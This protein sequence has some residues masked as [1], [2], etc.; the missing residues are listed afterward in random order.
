MASERGR[1]PAGIPYIIG[2]EAAERFSYYGMRSI[3][4]VFMT[5]FLMGAEGE[6][7]VMDEAEARGWYHSF[8]QAVYFLPLLGS[9][10][11]DGFLGKYR[12]ILWLS[13]VYCAG[14]LTLA[15][16][17]TRFG[18]ALG[19]GLIALGSGGI[20]PCVS[21]NVGDQFT[22]DNQHLLPKVFSLFYFSIN[23]G[24]FFATL[25]IPV[26][27]RRFG[28]SVAFGLPGLLMFL[29]TFVF[30]L[31]RDRFVRVPPT[32]MDFVR[33]SFS[34]DGLRA[35]GQLTVLLLFLSPF[36][37]LF[38]QTGSAWVLQAKS[39]DLRML[40]V[41]LLPSQVHA[42]NPILV[43][44]FAPLFAYGVY[45]AFERVFP[46]TPLRK[47]GIGFFL[48][49]ASFLIPAYVEVLIAGG[50]RPSVW[51]QIAAYAV[52]TAAEVLV[53]ITALEFF[54]TQAPRRMKSLI[55]A[56]KMLAISLGN[57][58][59]AIVNFAIRGSDGV[60]RLDGPAYYLF[61]AAVMFA[62]ATLFVAF[63]RVYRPKTFLQ[64]GSSDS[65]THEAGMK[66]RTVSA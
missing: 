49:G 42:V 1:W 40:G 13:L 36:Y 6:L 17:E 50:G 53:S 32:G 20:K 61:F 45:P 4:V 43:M 15:L 55:M 64:D 46:L 58:F 19:L 48:A 3:L 12:T 57:G 31:G 35:L 29:A 33:E 21:A 41:E 14:H 47:M 59:T 9:V 44:V 65:G 30:W 28:P 52:I 62:S 63:A 11:S 37:A 39:M 7:Q 34:V 25:L 56:L 5:E 66:S 8:A 26:L 16:D 27:L 51:W 2:N 23:F 60:A 18:L 38:D 10:L 54:Y 22:R 24:S